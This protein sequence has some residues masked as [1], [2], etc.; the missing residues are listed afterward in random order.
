E[1]GPAAHA[2]HRAHERLLRE[3]LRLGELAREKEGVA[4]EGSP[5][6]VRE[7]GEQGVAAH[8]SPSVGAGHDV[9]DRWGEKR[10]PRCVAQHEEVRFPLPSRAG[11]APLVV[12]TPAPPCNAGTSLYP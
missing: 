3:V 12:E 2:E 1:L 4:H 7:L 10:C 5:P 8:R 6:L 9:N 11:T